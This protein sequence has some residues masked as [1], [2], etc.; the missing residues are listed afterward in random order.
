MFLTWSS[1]KNAQTIS[2]SWKRWP[3][4]L[5]IEKYFYIR[6]NFCD[7]WLSWLSMLI[8]LWQVDKQDSQR[9][10]PYITYHLI[11]TIW[12][13]CAFQGHYDPLLFFSEMLLGKNVSVPDVTFSSTFYQSL[14][15][16]CNLWAQLLDCIFYLPFWNCAGYLSWYVDLYVI[17]CSPVWTRAYLELLKHVS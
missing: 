17:L 7:P 9:Y 4:E 13:R 8:L 1:M 12:I 5:T 2:H 11:C 15:T 16:T 6:M 10:A 3:P 14:E